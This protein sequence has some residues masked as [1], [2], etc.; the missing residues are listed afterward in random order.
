MTP[1]GPIATP[2]A[3]GN[4]LGVAALALA[5]ATPIVAVI[6]WLWAAATPG[7]ESLG[8]A[9]LA[10][11]AVVVVGVVALSVGFISL[12]VSRRNNLAKVSL[13]LVAATAVV[14]LLL[15]FPPTLWFG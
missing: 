1:T 9:V 3:T 11:F 10:F 8:V 14:L 15:L 4:R 6:G 7:P 13:L 12:P 5:V 2:R